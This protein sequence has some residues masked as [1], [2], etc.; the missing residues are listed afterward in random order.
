MPPSFP[1]EHVVADT[2]DLLKDRWKPG[3]IVAVSWGTEA[4]YGGKDNR[5]LGAPDFPKVWNEVFGENLPTTPVD[6]RRE[7]YI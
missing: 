1:F 6:S 4:K 5:R 3:E 2:L 7:I